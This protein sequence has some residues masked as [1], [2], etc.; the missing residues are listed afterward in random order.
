[1]LISNACVIERFNSMMRRLNSYY[2]GSTYRSALYPL[3]RL[4]R[5]SCALTLAHRHKLRRASQAFTRWGPN[6]TVE[7]ITRKG[8]KTNFTNNTRYKKM[9]ENSL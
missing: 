5:L 7:K 8:T 4:L 9:V 6:L 2:S 1:M 3:F